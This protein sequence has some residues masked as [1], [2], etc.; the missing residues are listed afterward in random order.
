MGGSITAKPEASIPVK[1]SFFSDDGISAFCNKIVVKYWPL[2][3]TKIRQ[4]GFDTRFM[5][6]CILFALQ[7]EDT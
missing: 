1:K 7:A 4:N 5:Y 6:L 3:P 2:L